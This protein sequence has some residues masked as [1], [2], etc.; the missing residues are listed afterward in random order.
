MAAGSP[1]DAEYEAA[2]KEARSWLRKAMD[3]GVPAAMAET[4]FLLIQDADVTTHMERDPKAGVALL[5]KALDLRDPDAPWELGIAYLRGLGVAQDQAKAKT[6]FESAAEAGN[7]EGCVY[8]GMVYA[9]GLGVP[10]DA[11]Q[12]MKWLGKAV[13]T[14]PQADA[15]AQAMIADLKAGQK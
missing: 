13:G 1:G 8:L 4:G 12:A 7:P 5:Q 6:L 3:A 10:K 9:Q 2:W 14:T 15:E 11:Q